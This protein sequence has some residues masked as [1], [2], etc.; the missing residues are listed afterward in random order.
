LDPTFQGPFFVFPDHQ[1]AVD[2]RKLDGICR[3]VFA[4]GEFRHCTHNNQPTHERLTSMGF[5]LQITKT[6]VDAFKKICNGFYDGKL[7]KSGKEYYIG[8]CSHTLKKIKEDQKTNLYL[9]HIINF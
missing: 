4:A 6:C 2:L 8:D 5:S 9:F 3:I 1:V 7:T